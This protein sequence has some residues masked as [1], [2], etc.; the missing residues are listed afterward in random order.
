MKKTVCRSL[1]VLI[2]CLAVSLTA[3]CARKA[4]IAVSP[5]EAPRFLDDFDPA[6][7]RAA[8]RH[9]LAY[10]DSRPADASFALGTRTVSRNR[11]RET[12]ADFLTILDTNP[13]PAELDRMVRERYEILQAS[14]TSGFN[15]GR[16]MLVTAYFQPV[17]EGRLTRTPPFIYPLYGLPPDLVRRRTPEGKTIF[18]R[19]EGGHLVPYWTRA[20][21]ERDRL[22]AGRELVWLRDP[23]DA[24]LL[25]VQGSGLIRLED[26][27]VRGLGYAG[28]NGHPYRSIGRYLVESGKIAEDNDGLEDIR[29]YLDEHPKERETILRRNPSFIFFAWRK[30]R[31]AI[32]NLGR[33]LTPGRSIA[34]DQGC[35]PAGGLAFLATGQPGTDGAEPL[36]RFVLAQ[37]TGSAIRGPGRVDLFLG[38]GDEAGRAAGRMQEK[39]TL[40]F[41]LLREKEG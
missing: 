24:F 22:L 39:G 14:G 7:L 25:H 38:S 29:R 28:K 11:L 8:V 9:S 12:L 19:M 6:S 10:L 3:S 32:G 21:I 2:L 36:S 15:P 35:F 31:G 23:F 20:E 13:S 30:T 18:G 41:L 27:T 26:G 5:D 16:R 33:E 34:V 4:L 37:D 1:L 40:Y 17:M